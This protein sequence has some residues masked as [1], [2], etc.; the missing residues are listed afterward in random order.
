MIL[1]TR[2]FFRIHRSP[3]KSG[4]SID[5]SSKKAHR[6]A[7]TPELEEA[8]LNTIEELPEESTRQIAAMLNMPFTLSYLESTCW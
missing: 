5:N 2:I 4:F 6:T 1:D 7:R 3:H 8:L